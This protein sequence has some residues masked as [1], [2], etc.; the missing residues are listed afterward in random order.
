M[1]RLDT[2]AVRETL[3]QIEIDTFRAEVNNW[4]V[5]LAGYLMTNAKGTGFRRDANAQRLAT[6]ALFFCVWSASGTSETAR[7]NTCSHV[8]ARSR[9]AFMRTLNKRVTPG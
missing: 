5:R 2:L 1:V 9:A 7:W 8:E 3:E 4:L 6:E